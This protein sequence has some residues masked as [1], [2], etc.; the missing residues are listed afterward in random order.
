MSSVHTIVSFLFPK[1][2][3]DFLSFLV[4]CDV[5]EIS[6]DVGDDDV[7]DEAEEQD[8]ADDEVGLGVV[9]LQGE[10]GAD[11]DVGW[12]QF[13]STSS[14]WM[15][16]DTDEGRRL[17]RALLAG[18]VGVEGSLRGRWTEMAL[19]RQ[20]SHCCLW[21][22]SLT[23]SV[24]DCAWLGSCERTRKMFLAVE[25][26]EINEISNLIYIRRQNINL[27]QVQTFCRWTRASPLSALLK[28]PLKE[29]PILTS[30]S[31]R[32]SSTRSCTGIGC[33]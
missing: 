21:K 5:D 8:E 17:V 27:H 26:I 28:A 19:R 20:L 33:R 11:C 24:W 23:C 18:R 10:L 7:V 4:F 32:S 6:G 15:M 3:R 12:R 1:E 31:C 25:G 14:M 2:H 13:S 9:L 22:T 16:A 30:P 29:P